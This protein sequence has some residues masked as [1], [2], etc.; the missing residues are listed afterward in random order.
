MATRPSVTDF[1]TP[2]DSIWSMV[3]SVWIVSILLLGGA[4]FPSPPFQSYFATSSLVII[5]VGLWR[6]QSGMPSGASTFSAILAAL[7]FALVLAQLIPIPYDVW[8]ALPG[9]EQAVRAFEAIG[10]APDSLALSLSPS[11]T[12]RAALSLLPPL[13]AFLGVLSVPKRLFWTMSG[14]IVLSA[15]LGALIGLVQ[16]SQGVASGL[17]FYKVPETA[18]HATGTFANRNFFAT[19]LFTCIPFLAAFTM[20]WTAKWKL[21]PV[22]VLGF[23]IVYI[24]LLVAV[25]AAVGSRAG[26]ILTMVSVLLTFLLVFRTS[27][28]GG[29]KIGTGKGV[30]IMLVALVV[31]AQTSMVGILRLAQTDPVNDFRNTITAVSYAAAKAQFPAGSGFGTFVPVYQLYE[32]NETIENPFINHAHNEWL[33]LAIEGGAPALVLMVLFLL[34]LVY[35]VFRS[36]KL[37][38]HEPTNAHIRA[39][40]CALALTLVHA[41]V[42]FPFR[43]DAMLTLFGL[44]VGFLALSTASPERLNKEQRPVQSNKKSKRP[45]AP[46]EFK[47]STQGFGGRRGSSATNSEQETRPAFE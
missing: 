9:R 23:M 16:K 22:L 21:R 7:S 31:M 45:I 44:C 43:T 14:A 20:F 30:L 25:L 8:R 46:R 26:T 47:P 33:E 4:G 39:A 3:L 10:T 42:D 32:T 27:S 24:G 41:I 38:A 34:W 6:L 35:V 19:Q 18:K 29:A 40:G 13:A 1:G 17:Y 37:A 12:R 5:G 28:Q 2:L 36:M 11:E 15:M